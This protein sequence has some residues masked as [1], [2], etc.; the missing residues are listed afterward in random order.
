MGL[1]IKLTYSIFLLNLFLLHPVLGQPSTPS[2]P[3]PLPT[4]NL[5]TSD[6]ETF[7]RVFGRPRQIGKTQTLIA[8]LV[9]DDREFEPIRIQL[10]IGNPNQTLV[11][12][13]PLLKA[14]TGIIRND[15]LS[16][17]QVDIGTAADVSL[18]TLQKNGLQANFDER[19]VAL[20]IIVPAT[21]RETKVSG[22]TSRLPPE[23]KEAL[24]ISALSGYLNIRGTNNFI[25]QGGRNETTGRQPLAV[26]L[27]GA[28]NFHNFVLEGNGIFAESSNPQSTLG[29]VRLVR[30]DPNNAIRYVLGDLAI[31]VRG[32]QNSVPLFGIA[33]TRD[34]S[35]QPYQIIT[36]VSRY[37]FFLERPSDVQIFTN[38]RLVQ[39]L[40]L[41][42]GQQDLRQL[43]LTSGIND[44]QLVVRDDL[45]R[46]Q[47][48]DFSTAVTNNLLAEG[49]Q[50]F[51]YGVGFPAQTI[52]GGKTYDWSQPNIFLAHRFGVSN[53]L[54]IG[55][56]AEANNRQQLVGTEGIFATVLGNFGWDLAFSNDQNLGIDYAWRLL[57]DFSKQG[58][59]STFDR[60][61][62]LSLEQ[63]GDRFINFGNSLTRNDRSLSISAFY[64]QQLFSGINAG[65][66]GQ[67]FLGRNIQD[68]YQVS[69]Q[70]S[71]SFNNGLNLNINLSDGRNS[72]G[73]REQRILV[74]LSLSF[75]GGKQSLDAS[76][77]ISK[78][79]TP[80][81]QINWNYQ[82][83][84]AS[85]ATS[86][87]VGITTNSSGYG[88]NGRLAYRGYRGV[89]EVTPDLFISPQDTRISAQLSFATAI[90]FADGYWALSRPIS[91]SFA[92]VVPQN[93]LSGQTVGVNPDGL[94]SY[95]T[96]A[97]SLGA[98]VVPNLSS[99]IVSRL[100]LEVPD[101]P[102]G[103]EA[104][105]A[106]YYAL[107]SYK[108]ATVV[109]VGT[110]A[111]VFIRGILEDSNGK[112]IA[113]QSGE[114]RSLSDP[115]WQPLTLF[116]N[117]VGKFALTGFKAGR[118]ELKIES[119]TLQF[120]IPEG[121]VG[122]YD[123]GILKLSAN[124]PLK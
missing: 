93:A 38:G 58:N 4:P 119:Q 28:I 103:V 123:L 18:E 50:Q 40:R 110:E 62:G 89:L 113:L 66:N 34:F 48:L 1:T 74:G 122:L 52:N 25:L 83:P 44:I 61:F 75:D 114:V 30:D 27:D 7:Q 2:S 68:A 22:D 53:T 54:T 23:A 77:D 97:D 116:T 42:A 8:P 105:E 6:D 21:I 67:Y 79:A 17:L 36:P 72:T 88:L 111:T 63:R 33:A 11:Q 112:A 98:G 124:P 109:R 94:G 3:T 80:T 85:D 13:S 35:L 118:Y 49:L 29:N 60:N 90:A 43:P 78:N 108:S 71:K 26:A 87:A 37:E 102:I 39:T 106:V 76:T 55:G 91:D 65:I 5:T 45:G 47:R 9:I 16:K 14:L 81:Q 121:K 41:P 96:R 101:L 84:Q 99:Y 57:Y 104:G 100:Q 10:Q 59:D 20:F 31:P 15:I 46:E 117:R 107:P 86:V 19:R 82:Q 115:Q 32:F 92:L 12:S 73:L 24:P 69:L 64:R 70:L 51:A 95:I 120:E 56:Y